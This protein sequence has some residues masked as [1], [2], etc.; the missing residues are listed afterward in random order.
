M[1]VSIKY[2]SKTDEVEI[3]IVVHVKRV[4]GAENGSRTQTIKWTTEGKLEKS[5]PKDG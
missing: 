1:L 5:G 3:K 2:R 4:A